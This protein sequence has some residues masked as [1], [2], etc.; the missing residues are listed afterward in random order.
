MLREWHAPVRLTM[1]QQVEQKGI[2]AVH[3][4]L[5]Q[6]LHFLVTDPSHPVPRDFAIGADDFH[7]GVVAGLGTRE[8]TRVEVLQRRVPD[9]ME[10]QHRRDFGSSVVQIRYGH[11]SSSLGCA[12]GVGR[13]I[14]LL[15]AEAMR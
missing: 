11:R 7:I 4:I 10:G 2:K 14:M 6:A 12:F 9:T 5:A 13:S 3:N 1:R 8:D 15:D